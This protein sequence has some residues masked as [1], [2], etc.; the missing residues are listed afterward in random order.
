MGVQGHDFAHKELK[1]QADVAGDNERKKT[2][3]T[4]A[5]ETNSLRFFV[6]TLVGETDLKLFH[7][8]V[9]YNDMFVA[10]SMSGHVVALLGD[11][12]LAGRP[13]KVTL[14]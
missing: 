14:L 11:R 6:A 5:I 12:E 3:K 10:T 1:W 2:F 8:L 7:S 4:Q 13:L 9:K